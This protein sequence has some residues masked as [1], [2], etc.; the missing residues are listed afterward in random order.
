LRW[1][2]CIELC[3]MVEAVVE[4]EEL[5][6]KEKL[7]FDESDLPDSLERTDADRCRLMASKD[8][9]FVWEGA[10]LG[11]AGAWA[12]GNE[13]FATWMGCWK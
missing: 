11:I 2:D 13:G 6:E 8:A 3:D 1:C 12:F 5:R 7:P 10:R 9:F 4:P